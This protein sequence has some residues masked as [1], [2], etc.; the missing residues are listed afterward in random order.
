MEFDHYLRGNKKHAWMSM[1]R[2]CIC[3]PRLAATFISQPYQCKGFTISTNFKWSFLV[4]LES[5]I[6]FVET[7]NILQL[8]LS[9]LDNTTTSFNFIRKLEYYL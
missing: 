7:I 4:N 2:L 3:Y 5:S 9:I 1:L 8:S 6:N